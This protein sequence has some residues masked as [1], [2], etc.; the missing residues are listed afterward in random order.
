MP[1]FLSRTARDIPTLIFKRELKIACWLTL[2]C[3]A[4]VLASGIPNAY[5][6]LNSTAHDAPAKDAQANE[7]PANEARANEAPAQRWLYP[8]HKNVHCHVTISIVEG[9][10]T[11][12]ILIQSKKLKPNIGELEYSKAFGILSDAKEVA[13]I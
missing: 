3:S 6:S 9:D 10:C 2:I 8:V 4:G 13:F 5:P 11:V 1:V 7:A 12:G